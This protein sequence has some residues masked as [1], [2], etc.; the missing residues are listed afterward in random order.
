MLKEDKT[1]N[2]AHA[3]RFYKVVIVRSEILLCAL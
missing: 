3:L 1:S 2:K